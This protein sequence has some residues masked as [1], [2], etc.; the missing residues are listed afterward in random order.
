MIYESDECYN[1]DIKTIGQCTGL[2][3][4]SGTLIFEGDIVVELY[5]RVS[6]DSPHNTPAYFDYTYLDAEIGEV[7]YKN[8]KFLI[9]PREGDNFK[10]GCIMPL[11]AFSVCDISKRA[12]LEVIGNT[13]EYTE[14]VTSQ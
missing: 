10:D 12:L 13:H 14:D 3:D 11:L 6:T 5:L 9:Q 7:I 2:K 1:V 4:R 8:G